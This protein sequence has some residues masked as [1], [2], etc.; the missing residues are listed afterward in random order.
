[1]ASVHE[2]A[3]GLRV[4]LQMPHERMPNLRLSPEETDNPI[5]PILSLKR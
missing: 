2:P 1:V 5:T 3:F 4:F